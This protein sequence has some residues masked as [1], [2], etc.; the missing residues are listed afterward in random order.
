MSDASRDTL[1]SVIDALID[2]AINGAETGTGSEVIMADAGGTGGDF[3]CVIT[4]DFSATGNADTIVVGG[5]GDE[6]REASVVRGGSA[7]VG[8]VDG[9]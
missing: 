4:V 8:R 7:A 5:D 6:G 1:G 9:T 3:F 2:V